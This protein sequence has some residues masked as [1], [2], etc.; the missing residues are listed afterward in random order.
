MINP[1]AIPTSGITGKDRK[2]EGSTENTPHGS[3]PKTKRIM[4]E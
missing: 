2:N 4:P 1:K 3:K